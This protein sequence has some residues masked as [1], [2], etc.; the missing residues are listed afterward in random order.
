MAKKW[1]YLTAKSLPVLF[2]GITSNN[3]WDFYWL[4]CFQ[5]HRTENKLKK[6]ETVLNDHDYCYAE[7]PDEDNKILKYNHGAK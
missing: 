5:S 6:H 3:N 2:R 1:H 7:I 4:N